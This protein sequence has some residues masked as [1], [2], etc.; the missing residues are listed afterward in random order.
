MSL[1]RRSLNILLIILCLILGGWAAC[2]YKRPPLILDNEPPSENNNGISTRD[3]IY[4]S[5]EKPRV[6]A[7][8]SAATPIDDSVR[9]SLPVTSER[10]RTVRRVETAGF[11][12]AEPRMMSAGHPFR[13]EALKILSGRLEETDSA[14]RHKILS[15][16]EHLRA[17]YAEKGASIEEMPP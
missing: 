4:I 9:M 11:K 17:S 16:C 3:T 5:G 1:K 2:I 13:Q 15:Y 14:S 12:D 6:S 7:D 8:S 10:E